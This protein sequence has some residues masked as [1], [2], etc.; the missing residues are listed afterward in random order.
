[1]KKIVASLLAVVMFWSGCGMCL[2]D[3]PSNAPE[4]ETV[5]SSQLSAPE[6]EVLKIVATQQPLKAAGLSK[7]DKLEISS[8]LLTFVGTLGILVSLVLRCFS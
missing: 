8:S 1:M 3:T 6:K 5:A 4:F 7:S 2:A